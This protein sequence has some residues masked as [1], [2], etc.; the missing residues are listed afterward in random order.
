MTRSDDGLEFPCRKCGAFVPSRAKRC[1]RC[2]TEEE[3]VEEILEEL[4]SLLNDDL[5]DKEEKPSNGKGTLDRE[6]MD[7]TSSTSDGKVRYKKV[8]KWPP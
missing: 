8:K 1:P 2:G 7:S 6:E 4:T 5:E 3:S